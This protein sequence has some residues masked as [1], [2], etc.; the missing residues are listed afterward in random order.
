MLFCPR[1]APFGFFALLP[2]KIAHKK[3]RFRPLW[4]HCVKRLFSKCLFRV[5]SFWKKMQPA[6]TWR[7]HTFRTTNTSSRWC[8]ALAVIGTL[9]DKSLC[10]ICQGKPIYGKQR[11]LTAAYECICTFTLKREAIRC[12]LHS[13]KCLEKNILLL[14]KCCNNLNDITIH[15]DRFV[16]VLVKT[17]VMFLC[18]SPGKFTG[19]FNTIS[20]AL[21]PRNCGKIGCWNKS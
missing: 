17:S 5:K 1:I 3:S 15:N 7:R 16:S 10:R 6:L 13:W 14:C 19:V 11:T 8:A 12:L 18:T 2:L 20:S 9:S 4:E 21:L